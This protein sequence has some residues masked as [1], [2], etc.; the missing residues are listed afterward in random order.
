MMLALLIKTVPSILK[1]P[2]PMLSL[3]HTHTH[4]LSFCLCISL[5][6]CTHTLSLYTH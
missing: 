3:L 2:L 1:F 5:T 4:Y 6:S